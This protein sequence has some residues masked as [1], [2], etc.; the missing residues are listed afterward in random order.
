MKLGMTLHG[1]A[2]A[3]H[4]RRRYAE[5][6]D[7]YRR[8]AAILQS[9]ALADVWHNWSAL[10]RETGPDDQARPLLESAAAI[11][12]KSW[13]LH[14]K[15]AIILRNLAELEAD[16]RHSARAEDLFNRSLQI[17][18]ASLPAGHP[19]TGVILQAYARFLRNTHRKTEAR[20]V[21]QRASAILA[22][23]MRATVDVSEF[24]P[25]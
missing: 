18:D 16:A 13:P 17:C 19:Q 7:F 5:A 24:K 11:Y 25:R 22:S 4:Q 3:A 14:P 12:E 9:A 1:L 20:Q 6:E 2:Q 23:G 15:L 21:G 8:A 10:Y